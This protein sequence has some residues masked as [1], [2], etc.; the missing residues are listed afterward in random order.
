[1]VK[2]SPGH[3]VL[4]QAQCIRARPR[5]GTYGH[6]TRPACLTP[7]PPLISLLE[8]AARSTAAILLTAT[9]VLSATSGL[10]ADAAAVAAA[11]PPSAG[12]LGPLPPQQ[13]PP[14]VPVGSAGVAAQPSAISPPDT[15][16]APTIRFTG[17]EALESLPP[18][19]TEFPPLPELQLP[20]YTTA[21]LRNGLRVF[22]LRD[23]EVP[24][25]RATLLMRGGQYGSPPGKVGV[26]TLTAYVQR[27]GGSVAH[28]A[29]SLDYRLEE[30]AA[31][32]EMGAGPQ[33]V[34][35]DMQC[36]A[37]DV[38]EVMGLMA[39]VVRTPAL[40]GDKLALYQA[41]IL[42]AL[43]HQND[44]PAAIGRRKIT[45]LLYG[46][47]SI[48]ARTPTKAGVSSISP[49]DLRAY[50]ARWERPDAA[51]LGVVGAFEPREMLALLDREFG[52]WAPAL[53]QPD[54]PP[55][56]PRGAPPA[57]PALNS[58]P[59][60]AA[61]AAATTASSAQPESSPPISSF[62]PAAAPPTSTFLSEGSKGA[63]PATTA[64][65][66]GRRPVVYLVDRPGLTQAYVL[67]AEPGISLSDPDLFALDVLGGIFNSFGGQLFDTLRSREGLAYSVSGGWDSPAYHQ[68]LFVAGGQTSSPGEFLRALR[69]ILGRAAT[70]APT[71]QEL[72]AA[73][74]ETL[75]SFVFNFASTASQLQRI[76]VYELLGLPQNF[77]FKY[78]QGIEGVELESVARAAAAH[79]HPERQAVVV[80]GDREV[81][82]LSLEVAGF[83][84][85]PLRLDD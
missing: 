6:T 59:A 67:T 85:L 22:L 46:P 74:A 69:Q 35:A 11:P 16:V 75:N 83:E 2:P 54:E 23:E 38:E 30:L 29:P 34:S 44:S 52:D 58:T 10:P 43:E 81:A 70:E 8:V 55:A 78:K 84:V 15:L 64:A 14:T 5:T 39:E 60:A 76:L 51:V 33:A 19:P 9:L 25:V 3:V 1:M 32:I 13:P 53:G 7:P 72:E 62:A 47:D 45:K 26:A 77:L 80:V 73:K 63:T 82:Q 65:P 12:I 66:S 56:V 71:A 36:L 37:E 40:P 21:K 68:G 4:C 61:A 27:A 49:D 28:P 24:L 18:L 42:N 31:S 48:Y 20:S 57:V 17:L 50:V 41:Q 79:L